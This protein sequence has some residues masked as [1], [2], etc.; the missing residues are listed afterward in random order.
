MGRIMAIDYGRKRVGIAITD[1]LKMIAQG[2]DTV[3]AKDI[4]TF[5]KNYC[6]NE[7]VEQFVVGDPRDLQNREGEAMEFV[8]PFV[9]KLKEQFPDIPVE[10]MDERFTSKMAFQAM[11]DGGLKKK[12]RQNKALIDKV[13]A[14]ILLQS[15]LEKENN[16]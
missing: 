12:D 1:P 11:V 10:M 8:K 7:V 14:T 9:K 15:Y 5:L 3:H 4:F 6:A 2:L 13:S 16:N